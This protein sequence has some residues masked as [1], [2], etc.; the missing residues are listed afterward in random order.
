MNDMQSNAILAVDWLQLVIAAAL[1]LGLTTAVSLAIRGPLF[2]VLDMICGSVV[3]ARFWTTFAC[4][5]LVMGPLFL[6]FTAAG[7]AANLADFVR[8]AVYLVSF[9]VIVAFLVM[10]AAVMMGVSAHGMDGREP[11]GRGRRPADAP[12]GAA[13]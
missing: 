5:L 13:E 4:V 3:A 9:G 12:R 7:G 11:Q 8:R 2:A 6:V 10:G 1:T